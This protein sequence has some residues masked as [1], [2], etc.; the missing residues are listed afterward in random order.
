M[1][2]RTWLIVGAL[3]L[4]AG[5][6]LWLAR[7]GLVIAQRPGLP[8]G[9]DPQQAT[10]GAVIRN[11]DRV[12]DVYTGGSSSCPTVPV[13][14]SFAD[15]TLTIRVESRQRGI[16]TADMAFRTSTIRFPSGVDHLDPEDVEVVR[17]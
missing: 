1:R 12:V 8:A 2:R 5:L 11:D 4:V 6:G 17:S 9:V 13:A 7:P 10:L 3:V 15:G 16:C 14:A